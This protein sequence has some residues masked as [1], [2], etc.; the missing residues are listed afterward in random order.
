M[1]KGVNMGEL[2]KLTPDERDLAEEIVEE[3]LSPETKAYIVAILQGDNWI[4]QFNKVKNK[5]QLAGMLEEIKSR[6]L[7]GLWCEDEEI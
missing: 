5:W 6:I 7:G 4:I 1:L 2:I 3:M